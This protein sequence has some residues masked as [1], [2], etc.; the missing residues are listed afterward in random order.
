MDNDTV[1][2]AKDWYYGLDGNPPSSS[3]LDLLDTVLHELA[4]ASQ[5][6]AVAEQKLADHAATEAA[7]D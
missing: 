5:A 3:A 1:L 7:S 2:G 4:E 6:R